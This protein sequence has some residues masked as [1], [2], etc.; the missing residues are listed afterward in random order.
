LLLALIKIVSTKEYLA[1]FALKILCAVLHR[2]PFAGLI[3]QHASQQESDIDREG[4]AEEEGKAKE[5]KEDKASKEANGEEEEDE[6]QQD[7][8]PEEQMLSESDAIK[9]NKVRRGQGRT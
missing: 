9:A 2:F 5:D 7:E 3:Q 8:E 6:E 1:S 4:H